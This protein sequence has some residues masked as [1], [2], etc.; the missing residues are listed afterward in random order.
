[1]HSLF[2]H[3]K[4]STELF[5]L[6]QKRDAAQKYSSEYRNQTAQSCRYYILICNMRKCSRRYKNSII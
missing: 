2:V 4:E 5:M 3:S 1:M 6:E